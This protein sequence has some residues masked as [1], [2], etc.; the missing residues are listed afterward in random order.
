[1]T[2]EYLDFSTRIMTRATPPDV[3]PPFPPDHDG[4][5]LTT[6]YLATDRDGCAPTDRRQ[7][8]FPRNLSH[9]RDK[10]DEAR[11]EEDRRLFTEAVFRDVLNLLADAVDNVPCLL[12]LPII[13]GPYP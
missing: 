10:R 4:A 9:T 3:G 5:T 2:T 12:L 1:M 6:T 11:A 13:L 8:C 7:G